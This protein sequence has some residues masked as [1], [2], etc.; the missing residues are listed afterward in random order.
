MNFLKFL[1][2]KN[3]LF[4]ETF[5]KFLNKKKIFRIFENLKIRKYF[6]FSEKKF[7]FELLV[8]RILDF[9]RFL[10]EIN[11]YQFL[12]IERTKCTVFTDISSNIFEPFT[13][14]P[15]NLSHAFTQTGKDMTSEE[16][17]TEAA[18]SEEKETQMPHIES[19]RV[20]ERADK[21]TTPEDRARFKKFF[22]AATQVSLINDIS[23]NISD[24]EK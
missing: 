2:L 20:E 10:P 16:V 18:E 11:D 23:R 5:F 1:K 19:R 15:S 24:N 13:S 4:F 3:V 12:G 6:V 22:F 9:S 17:Q 21:Q 7:F 14:L 8:F